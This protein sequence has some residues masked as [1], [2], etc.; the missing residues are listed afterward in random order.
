MCKMDNGEE[1]Q[2]RKRFK[3]ILLHIIDVLHK[4][5]DDFYQ[6]NLINENPEHL[7]ILKEIMGKLS[8]EI[9]INQMISCHILWTGLINNELNNIKY[10]IDKYD[11][12]SPVNIRLLL[13]PFDKVND[14]DIINE[15]DINGIWS[16]IH[17]LIEIT[18][19][20]ISIM[21]NKRHTFSGDV[22]IEFFGTIMEQ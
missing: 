11:D 21:R 5:V 18:T 6:E 22:D 17:I 7:R 4:T 13:L 1:I 19:R 12:I 3:T 16:Y 15:D 14:I 10:I 2:L 9:M 20:Y 8:G